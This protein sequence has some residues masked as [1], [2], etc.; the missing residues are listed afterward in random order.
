MPIY[1]EPV[2]IPF[3]GVPLNPDIT[4][5]L[6]TGVYPHGF[7]QV[8]GIY[9]NQ[10]AYPSVALAK[11]SLDSLS[12]PG[13]SG[14]VYWP[15][16][17]PFGQKV[18]LG[19]NQIEYYDPVLGVYLYDESGVLRQNNQPVVDFNFSSILP[20]P[21][22]TGQTL[23]S[24]NGYFLTTARVGRTGDGSWSNFAS[25]SIASPNFTGYIAY[26]SGT[27]MQAFDGGGN[28]GDYTDSG[29]LKIKIENSTL[30][31]KPFTPMLY[32]DEVPHGTG[33]V[34]CWRVTGL[35]ETLADMTGDFNRRISFT[36]PGNQYCVFFSGYDGST[37]LFITY[38]NGGSG[39]GYFNAQPVIPAF[40]PPEAVLL[41]VEN[42]GLLPNYGQPTSDTFPEYAIVRG[43]YYPAMPV[44][45][46]VNIYM[47]MAWEADCSDAE[48]CR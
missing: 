13:E 47:T 9:W 48:N 29:V 37:P 42:S 11:H 38:L 33:L 12:P 26:K 10:I 15:A 46:G 23:G 20:M 3:S 43:G 16:P 28:F 39:I 4:G 22:V 30:Y 7:G 45:V 6:D 27:G 32:H 21:S 44:S 40:Q 35:F 36:Q 1:N 14:D 18:I 24:N 41:H 17:C 5:S 8:F 31:F 25:L 19:F 34:P 2:G